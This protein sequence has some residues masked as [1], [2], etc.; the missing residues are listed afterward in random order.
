MTHCL[1]SVA[2][3]KAELNYGWPLPVS[4]QPGSLLYCCEQHGHI[5]GVLLDPAW[6]LLHLCLSLGV[7]GCSQCSSATEQANLVG[8]GA[9]SGLYRKL[10]AWR[11]SVSLLVL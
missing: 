4:T 1:H 10:R 6:V 5:S 9:A 8:P 3:K 7:Q 11:S 2:G